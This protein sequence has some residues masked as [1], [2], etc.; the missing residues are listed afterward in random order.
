M[1]HKSTVPHEAE[2]EST[3]EDGECK[4]EKLGE[5]IRLSASL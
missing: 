3:D 2:K 1:L 4:Q 5:H